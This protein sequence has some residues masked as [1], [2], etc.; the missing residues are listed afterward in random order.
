MIN[1]ALEPPSVMSQDLSGKTWTL[2]FQRSPVEILPCPKDASRVGGIR[3]AINKIQ[4]CILRRSRYVSYV[5]DAL[6]P[7]CVTL[8]HQ[9]PT[10]GFRLVLMDWILHC[11]INLLKEESINNS[12]LAGL[13]CV[14]LL[15][16]S[17]GSENYRCCFFLNKPWVVDA[18]LYL[19]EQTWIVDSDWSIESHS[20]KSVI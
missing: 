6:I 2:T 10:A 11:Q 12:K 8:I 3:L 1:S 4:V 16:G 5:E 15:S 13:P 7:N 9:S 20:N 17:V 19:C 14:N 18:R